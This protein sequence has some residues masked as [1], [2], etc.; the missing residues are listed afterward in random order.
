MA[1]AITV[2]WLDDSRAQRILWL[3]EEL[4]LEYDVKR[5]ARDATTNLAPKELQ[6]AHPLGKS[7]VVVITDG[8]HSITLAE[9]GAIAEFLIERYGQ[10]K[11]FVPADTLN[12]QARADYLYWMHYAEGSA[13]LPL[14]LSIVFAK[15]PKSAPWFLRP[16]V[17]TIATGATTGFVMPRLKQHFA[18]I[19]QA[20]QGKE[21]FVDGKLTGADIMMSFIAE[22]LFATPL[23]ADGYPNIKR[24]HAAMEQRELYQVA[25]KKGG[26]NDMGRFT[27]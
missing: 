11:L 26:K 18:Y 17:Q 24:W 27:R 14:M 16:V 8:A 10:G 6:E 2:H 1:P 12:F 9:S 19:D 13:M 23:S 15:M 21:Y 3:L 20:L 7:P 5:Y 22:G 25:E 4:G